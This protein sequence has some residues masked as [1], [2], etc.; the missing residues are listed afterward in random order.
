LAPVSVPDFRWMLGGVFTW[1][2]MLPIAAKADEHPHIKTNNKQSVF[3][4]NFNYPW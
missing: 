3:T 2:V 1:S 4:G